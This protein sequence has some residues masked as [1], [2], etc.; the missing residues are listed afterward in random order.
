M[1]VFLYLIITGAG[2]SLYISR[3]LCAHTQSYSL[4][5][6]LYRKGGRAFLKTLLPRLNSKS[7]GGGL[8]M[9]F[10]LEV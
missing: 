4:F 3:T 9:P 6:S 10:E 2:L 5:L 7:N 1:N 8:A